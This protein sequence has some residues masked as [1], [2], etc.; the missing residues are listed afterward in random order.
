MPKLPI[1]VES[2]DFVLASIP[3]PV[4]DFESKQPR[5]DS[6]GQP[7]FTVG[8]VALGSDGADIINVKV[9]YEP[10]GLVL[11]GPVKITGLVATTWAMSDRNGVSFRC[12]RVEVLPTS[13]KA[14]VAA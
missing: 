2:L 6:N 9:N 14:T 7:I 3:E 11:A 5:L 1:Q 13:T 12:E 4:I 8:V 10:K